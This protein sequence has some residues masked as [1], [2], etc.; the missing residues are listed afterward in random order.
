MKQTIRL[1]ESDLRKMVKRVIKDVVKE[2]KVIQNKIPYPLDSGD[3]VDD[4]GNIVFA[5]KSKYADQY[6]HPEAIA[7]RD[8]RRKGNIYGKREKRLALDGLLNDQSLEA[9][10]RYLKQSEEWWLNELSKWGQA[11]WMYI[12]LGEGKRVGATSLMELWEM[13]WD[14][15][16][17]YQFIVRKYREKDVTGEGLEY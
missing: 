8:L 5:E 11:Q 17:Y 3:Y 9:N 7:K 4:E 6:N 10:L 12:D 16:I 13:H 15:G 2:G 1:T 14:S